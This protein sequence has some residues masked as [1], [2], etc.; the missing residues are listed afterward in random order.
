[1]VSSL[2]YYKTNSVFKALSSDRK[3]ED[4]LNIYCAC[5]D[6]IH[7]WKGVD[8]YNI[9]ADGVSARKEP[10]ILITTTGFECEGVYD[11]KYQEA[12]NLINGLYDDNVYKDNAFLPVIYELDNRDEW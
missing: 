9:V 12:T 2:C 4:G 6:E 7:T 3:T 8:L 5:C 11:L 10:L 1:M